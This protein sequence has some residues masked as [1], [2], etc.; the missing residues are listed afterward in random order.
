MN[1]EFAGR[2]YQATVRF[3]KGRPRDLAFGTEDDVR[4]YLDMELMDGF[5]ADL[6]SEYADASVWRDGELVFKGRLHAEEECAWWEL[7]A[8]RLGDFFVNTVWGR[9]K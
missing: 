1:E 2:P 7:E 9:K 6:P 3:Q 4:D 5:L 8:N